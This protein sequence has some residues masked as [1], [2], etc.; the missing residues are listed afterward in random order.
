MGAC[1]FRTVIMGRFDVNEAFHEAVDRA[2]YA[3][4]HGGYTGTIAEKDSVELLDCPH[5]YGTQ[6]YEEWIN[7]K[8]E[9]N[10]RWGPAFAIEV[11]GSE[12]KRLKKLY[13]HRRKGWK[14]FVFFGL[15]SS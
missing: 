14:V 9:E 6:A 5:N 4:G 2:R 3:Y 12:Y 10:D 15:A 13:G 11:R 1:S 8:I 7:R